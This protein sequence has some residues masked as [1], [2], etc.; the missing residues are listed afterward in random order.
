M[1]A[2]PLAY[3]CRVSFAVPGPDGV[4]RV[5]AEGQI[6]AAGDPVLKGRLGMFQTVAE[7]VEQATAAPG[8]FRAVHI[9]PPDPAK[10]EETTDEPAAKRRPGRRPANP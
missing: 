6:I 9:P 10:D 8:E 4:P 7:Y 3:R 5:I 1:D 2:P